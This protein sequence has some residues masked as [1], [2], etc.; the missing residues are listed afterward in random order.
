LLITKRERHLYNKEIWLPSSSPNDQIISPD[1]SII[2]IPAE[3]T[4]SHTHIYNV[5]VRFLKLLV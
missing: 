4:A 1:P 2:Y 5:P 3:E